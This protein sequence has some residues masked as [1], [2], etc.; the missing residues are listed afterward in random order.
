MMI[1]R[2]KQY[3]EVSMSLP[4]RVYVFR[5]GVSEVRYFDTHSSPAVLKC[6]AGT[7]QHRP[8]RR[9]SQDNRRFQE[10]ELE[11]WASRNTLPT[12]VDDLHMRWQALPH[13]K[14][15]PQ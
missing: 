4:E 14:L 7:A 1:E 12:S 8:Q 6:V 11:R 5:A 15:A 9:A 3:Q 10:S 2:L 13:P